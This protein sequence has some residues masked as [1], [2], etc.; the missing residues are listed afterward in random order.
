MRLRDELLASP[1]C[2]DEGR[3]VGAD[4]L[5]SAGPAQR[6]RP[7][8]LVPVDRRQW[9]RPCCFWGAQTGPNPT[10]RRKAGTKHHILTDGNGIPLAAT[11]TGANR[12]DV[13][14]LIKL[15][16]SIP[17]I[18]GKPGRPRRRPDALYADRAYDSRWHRDEL[19]RRGIRPHLARRKTEHGSGLGRHRWPVERT[20][21]WLHQ[22]RRLRVR[23][24]KR[25]DLHEAFLKLGCIRI[26]LKKLTGSFC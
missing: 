1:A 17:P 19:R 5:R 2:L 26:C 3:R 8:R 16:D 22:L 13:T 9:Q 21:S 23:Y 14:Q 20:I 6:R 4:P 24:E 15:V 7:D 11:I 18:Y 10:D 25:N 12:H